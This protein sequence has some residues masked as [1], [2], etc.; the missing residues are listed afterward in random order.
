MSDNTC[1]C[2][3]EQTSTIFNPSFSNLEVKINAIA[4]ASD[5]CLGDSE[6]VTFAIDTC[7]VDDVNLTKAKLSA[8]VDTAFVGTVSKLLN[9]V[10]DL[11]VTPATAIIAGTF[12]QKEGKILVNVSSMTDVETA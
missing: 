6:V 10:A 4:P 1:G 3:P 9:S 11:A 12:Y 7:L 5:A 8:V 2:T